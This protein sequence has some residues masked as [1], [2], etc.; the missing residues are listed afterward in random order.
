MLVEVF[1]PYY[2]ERDPLSHSVVTKYSSVFTVSSPFPPGWY[3]D[4][5]TDGSVSPGTY[6]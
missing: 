5:L 6:M 4:C 1:T 3:A 2:E